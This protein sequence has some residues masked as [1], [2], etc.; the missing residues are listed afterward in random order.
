MKFGLSQ[1]FNPTPDQAKKVFKAFFVATTVIA[2]ILQFFPQIPKHFSDVVNSYVV[3]AN[4]F[5][6]A[7]TR[8]FGVQVDQ[9]SK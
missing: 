1:I 9:P 2:L 6:F 5:V 7:L 3:E 8:L 4:G